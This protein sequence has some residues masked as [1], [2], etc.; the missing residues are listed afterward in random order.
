MKI[1][2][3]KFGEIVINGSTYTNDVIIC[4]DTVHPNWWRKQ[5]HSLH[6]DDLSTVAEEKPS[7]L[8]VG[9]GAS[10]IMSVPEQTK[11][12]LREQGIHPEIYDTKRA[13]ERFNELSEKGEK[14]AA[15]LHLTC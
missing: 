9:C 13:V 4:S 10:G 8:I 3:Y 15:A 6:P 11:N 7:I 2:S 12:F 5:G 14:P 1:D